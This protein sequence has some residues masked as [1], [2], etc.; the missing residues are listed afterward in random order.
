MMDDTLEWEEE[1]GPLIAPPS[2]EE[3]ERSVR[4]VGIPDGE[5]GTLDCLSENRERGIW[6][7][8]EVDEVAGVLRL[9]ELEKGTGEGG[10]EGVRFLN[11]KGDDSWFLLVREIGEK[12]V[13]VGELLR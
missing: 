8:I 7:G 9:E 4:S 13:V 5:E 1:D 2:E 12:S 3:R 6:E 10:G 11:V